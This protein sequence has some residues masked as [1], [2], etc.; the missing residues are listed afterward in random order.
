MEEGSD[1][2]GKDNFIEDESIRYFFNLYF[3]FHIN[4][5]QPF[6]LFTFECF[7]TPILITLLRK[8]QIINFESALDPYF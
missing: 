1:T 5:S 7:Q 3:Q 2:S 6:I 8:V 4:P